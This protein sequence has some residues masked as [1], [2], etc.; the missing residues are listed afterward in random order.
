MSRPVKRALTHRFSR[1]PRRRADD[2]V[3]EDDREPGR[4]D[5]AVAQVQVGTAHRARADPDAQLAYGRHRV[6]HVGHPQWL[7]GTL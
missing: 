4:V 6:G 2:L 7:T 3:A 5:L 1:P